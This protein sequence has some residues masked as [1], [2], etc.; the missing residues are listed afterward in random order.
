MVGY[1]QQQSMAHETYIG[2]G[3]ESIEYTSGFFDMH[4]ELVAAT[5][6]QTVGVEFSDAPEVGIQFT[7]ALGEEKVAF[8]KSSN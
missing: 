7:T 3:A 4:E 2:A 6:D 8:K 1:T 5:T